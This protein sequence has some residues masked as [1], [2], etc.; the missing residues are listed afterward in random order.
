MNKDLIIG[1]LVSVGVH[2]FALNP[3]AGKQPPPVRE[4]V[5]KEEIIQMEMPPLDEEEDKKV[6]E[7]QDEP[8]ENV[9][10]PPSLIDLPT[11]VPVNAFT[12]PLQPPPPPGMNVAR[13]AINIPVNPPGANFGKGIKDLFD[14]NNLDQKPVGR[15]QNPPQ[16]P[17]EMSRAGIS[18]EVVVEFII[19]ANGDVVDTRVIRSS[20]REFE[21]PAM[22]AVQKWKFKPGRKA[23]KNVSTRV[24]QLI[25]FNLEDSK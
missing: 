14:I 4:A 19:S 2:L 10:A 12:Q 23:G 17:Y 20:H 9:M 16:Y 15:V 3:F 11:V 6:E 21:V 13:G 24:S 18:G 22:Q 8:V 5:V 25:E 1:L 7:L